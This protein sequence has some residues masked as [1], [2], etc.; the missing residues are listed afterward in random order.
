MHDDNNADV[1][2]IL[3]SIECM[4]LVLLCARGYTDARKAGKRCWDMRDG[5]EEGSRGEKRG[6]RRAAI[7]AVVYIR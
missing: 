1:L 6:T 7:A 5:R 3:A 4:T 2:L